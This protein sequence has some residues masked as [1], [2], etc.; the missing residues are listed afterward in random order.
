MC[1]LPSLQQG[2]L[3]SEATLSRL[4][5]ALF[6][7]L[8]ASC[9]G[10]RGVRS[11][12]GVPSDITRPVVSII[13]PSPDSVVSGIVPISAVATDDRQMQ[14]VKFYVDNCL[15][16][17]DSAAPWSYSWD[18]RAV[19]DSTRHLLQARAYDAARNERLSEPIKAL[20]RSSFIDRIPPTISMSYA[21]GIASHH[22]P[23]TPSVVITARDDGSGIS[24]D[25]V[26]VDI[27]APG[28]VETPSPEANVYIPLHF[29]FGELR[30]LHVVAYDG[31]RALNFDRQSVTCE[32]LNAGIPDLAGN[33]CRVV[34]DTLIVN[35]TF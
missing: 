2:R 24:W 20:V 23:I 25:S 28:E 13:D 29:E 12:D 1:S 7:L 26:F 18:C 27:Y 31:R 22:G 21:P 14:R 4:W 10:D 6:L 35:Y 15:R 16:H 19:S 9:S 17:I 5:S 32:F 30:R 34:G 3:I 33:H 11:K 8:A